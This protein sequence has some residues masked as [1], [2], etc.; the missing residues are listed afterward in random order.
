MG[1]I[2]FALRERVIN[3]VYINK[4]PKA[5]VNTAI[6]FIFLCF[7]YIKNNR[8]NIIKLIINNRISFKFIM[9]FRIINPDSRIPVL[10]QNTKLTGI[11]NFI[12]P[13]PT[14]TLPV[15]ITKPNSIDNA[16]PII[17]NK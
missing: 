14:I 3:D 5:P 15:G 8:T 13:N 6:V 1:R 17:K 10:T 4:Y 2:L 12:I 9:Y 16:A 11:L 7:L